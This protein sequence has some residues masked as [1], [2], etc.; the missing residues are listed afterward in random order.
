MAK[1]RPSDLERLVSL[2]DAALRRDP[3]AREVLAL[4]LLHRCRRI[5]RHVWPWL[6]FNTVNDAIEDALLHY[7]GAPECF[8]PSRARLDTFIVRDAMY[9]AL[10]AVR[11]DKRRRRR[12]ARM[13]PRN[14]A[15]VPET[16]S[17]TDSRENLLTGLMRRVA[18]GRELEFLEAKAHGEHRTRVL[19]AILGL[20]GLSAIDQRRSVKRVTDKLLV[21][22]R[23]VVKSDALKIARIRLLPDSPHHRKKRS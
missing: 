7:L 14:E 13:M 18:G 6:D 8:D 12:D 22:M 17:V 21:R 15:T 9:R 2:H 4:F 5:L 16:D 10:H 1:T 11:A 23:R 20:A 19:A 3:I